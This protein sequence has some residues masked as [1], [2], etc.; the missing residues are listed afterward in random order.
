MAAACASPAIPVTVL[1]GFL[2]SGKTTLLKHLLC[3]DHGLRV[4]V[5][6]NDMADLNVDASALAAVAHAPEKLVSMQNGCICCTLREDLLVEV[7]K[8]ARAGNLD[9]I[10]IESSGISEPQLVAE[11]FEF[12]DADGSRLND[13]ARLD[14]AVTVVD[15]SSFP[16]QW[17][18]LETLAD[19]SWGI[20]SADER[21]VAALL[22]QQIEFAD[23]LVVNKT[24]L[25]PESD[26][27][28]VEHLVRALNPS[29]TIHRSTHSIVPLKHV[30]RTGLF[31]LARARSV[32][33]CW[34]DF[35]GWI[36]PTLKA[37]WCHLHKH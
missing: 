26:T 20:D 34:P 3:G 1:S 31:D 17:D 21:S 19:R 27:V 4:G 33:A 28:R 8:L 24:D 10:V 9:A 11:T 35:S 23:V 36:A 5:I 25:V 6:V 22:Q 18:S 29:A 30:L 32:S 37:V 16:K 7:A 12:E 2:G 14:T 13:I 15:A